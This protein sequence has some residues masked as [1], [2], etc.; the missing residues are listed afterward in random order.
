MLFLNGELFIRCIPPVLTSH[1]L[2]EFFSSGFSQS[3]SQQ[4]DHHFLIIIVT[5]VCL[6]PPVNGC[7]KESYF[8]WFSCRLGTDEI[9]K[10]QIFAVS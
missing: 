9:R 5:E 2:M 6:H 7:G 1:L 4:L 3:V 8:I 10:T